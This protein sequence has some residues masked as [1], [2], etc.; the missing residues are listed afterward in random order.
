[1]ASNMTNKSREIPALPLWK[2]GEQVNK[3]GNSFWLYW[4]LEPEQSQF[5]SDP[6]AS[7][8]INHK[9]HGTIPLLIISQAGWFYY[10]DLPQ[11]TGSCNES[12]RNTW[13]GTLEYI[14]AFPGTQW[15]PQSCGA[16]SRSITTIL[17][18]DRYFL[19]LQL[20][21]WAFFQLLVHNSMAKPLNYAHYMI[22]LATILG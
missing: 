14:F 18:T 2:K 7:K 5:Q 12:L 17:V 6:H 3:R 10:D 21:I 19:Q 13:F 11:E 16:S 9:S 8:L 4:I 15:N 22:F 20:D 1:M